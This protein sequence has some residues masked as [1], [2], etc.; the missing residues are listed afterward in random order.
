VNWRKCSIRTTTDGIP[1]Y[2]L[3]EIV[4]LVRS[5]RAYARSPADQG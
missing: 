5:L 3:N 2:C 1:N 4:I